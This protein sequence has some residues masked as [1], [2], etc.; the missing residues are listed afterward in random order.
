MSASDITLGVD[1][2]TT[3]TVISTAGPD[4]EAH[5][6]RFVFEGAESTTFRSCLSLSAD[7]DQPNGRAVEAGPWAID[8]YL[9]DRPRRV[10]S[11]R[12]RASRRAP[13][14]ETTILGRR[15]SF[16]DLLS[17]FL[18]AAS[19]PCRRGTGATRPDG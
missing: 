7:P 15:Y 14:P 19:R 6:A 17:A 13:L 18:L 16:E 9:E 3:N 4:G 11:S 2:G 12:S 8:A 5:L 10:S 1:F